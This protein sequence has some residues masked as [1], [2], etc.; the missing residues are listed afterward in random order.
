M[1][2]EGNKFMGVRVSGLL[3]RLRPDDKTQVIFEYPSHE[4]GAV[5]SQSVHM[6]VISMRH[7]DP[8]NAMRRE[9]AAGY[10]GTKW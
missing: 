1:A 5:E 3:W 8:L 6:M 9:E 2:V 10:T 4:D 7:S